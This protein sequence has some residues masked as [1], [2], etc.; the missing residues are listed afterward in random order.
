M[1]RETAYTTTPGSKLRKELKARK[2]TQRNFADAIGMRP[3]HL[4][5]IINGKRPVTEQL[6]LKFEKHLEVPASVWIEL[7]AKLEFEQKISIIEESTN[8][9]DN[10]TL[11]Q[12]DEL[13]DLKTIFKYVGISK[14]S[15]HERIEF[16][17]NVLKFS[18]PTNQK[19][20][21][22]GY[23]HKSE[24]TGLDQR[25]IA[26]WSVLAMYEASQLQLP[27]GVFHKEKCD[28]LAIKLSEIFND[29]HNTLNRVS[30]TFSEYG[31]KFCIVPKLPHAS[32]DGFSFY[33]KGCPCIVITKRFD[34]IDNLAFAV[35][36]EVGHLKMHLATNSVGK[37]SLI[38]PDIEQLAKEEEQANEYAANILIPEDVWKQQ[39]QVILSPRVIQA[40]FTKWAKSINK[41]KWIV[42]GRASH[43]TNI[44][45]FK[46]DETRKIN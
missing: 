34:R 25:M 9:E 42:L 46:S 7:Q 12:Y 6:A 27:N 22:Q 19:R 41:N 28:E 16:C 32:I 29:N 17:Q 13:Y 35:L 45:M 33:D 3:S 38:N 40:R 43:E 24:K 39:P 8:I 20:F 11:T 44:Y 31:V 37:I 18:T 30:R 26:T 2:I 14:K 10:K 4:S 15:T 21:I 36:H 5:E 1:K 23:F